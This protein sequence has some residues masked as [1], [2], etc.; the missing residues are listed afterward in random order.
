MAD[1]NTIKLTHDWRV[2]VYALKRSQLLEVSRDGLRVKRKI[3]IPDEIRRGRFGTTSIIAI[4]I[5]KQWSTVEMIT[6]TLSYYGKINLGE[7]HVTFFNLKLFDSAR[8]MEGNKPIPPDLKNY[9]TQVPDMGKNTC[10]IV[11][12]ESVRSATN[13]FHQLKDKNLHGMRI[14]LLGPRMRRTL[15]TDKVVDE[16]TLTFN[17]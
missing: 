17:L 4:R 2:T 11:D 8:I 15:Y 6:K 10:A 16:L 9:A 12:F 3:P 5:P 1:L 14:A 13:C 7:D